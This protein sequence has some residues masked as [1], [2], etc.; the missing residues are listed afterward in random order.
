M[1]GEI[2]RGLTDAATAEEVLAVVGRP[3]IRD[4]ITHA[5]AS[6]GVAVGALVA[7]RV[8]H[9]LDHG[10]EEVWLDLFGAM[11]GSPQPAATAVERVLARAFPDPARVQI[12]RVSS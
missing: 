6:D 1:L 3:G 12:T 2:L 4:R 11:S 7:S 9:L 8:R 5:A 10:D